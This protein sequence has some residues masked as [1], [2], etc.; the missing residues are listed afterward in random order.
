MGI[1]SNLWDFNAFTQSVRTAVNAE[2]VLPKDQEE[3]SNTCCCF[4]SHP[5]QKFG[6]NVDD[7]PIES[8][9][10]VRGE[11]DG[12]TSITTNYENNDS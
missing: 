2:C 6:S 11:D 3:K 8:L 10:M 7:D 5:N 1:L 9:K 12:E 4:G